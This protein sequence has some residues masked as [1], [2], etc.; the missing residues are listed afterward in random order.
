MAEAVVEDKQ[1]IATQLSALLQK[2]PFDAKFYNVTFDDDGNPKEVEI[3]QAVQ[4]V[5]MIRVDLK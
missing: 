5:V 3:E 2:S 1:A 4:Q